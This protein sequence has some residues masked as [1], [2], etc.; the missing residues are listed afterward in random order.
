MSESITSELR[1]I[2]R[3][4]LAGEKTLRDFL[5]W[6]ATFALD[7]DIPAADRLILDRLA[8]LGEEIAQGARDEIDFRTLAAELV[9]APAHP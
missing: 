8:L 3:E 4:Y 7:P 2:L 5:A 6:E 1:K 9:V